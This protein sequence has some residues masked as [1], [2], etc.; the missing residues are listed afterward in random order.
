MDEHVVQLGLAIVGFVAFVVLL[1]SR[2]ALYHRH[3]RRRDMSRLLLIDA[4]LVIA[5]LELV[6][7]ALT[8]LH[9]GA[10]VLHGAFTAVAFACRGALVAGAIA[11]V[12]TL[13]WARA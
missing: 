2:W 3:E 13:E 6:A 10:D 8:E 9:P 7:D 1:V 12:A 11:L 4:L 5:G